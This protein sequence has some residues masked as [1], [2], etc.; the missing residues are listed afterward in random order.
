MTDIVKAT[1]ISEAISSAV[2]CAYSQVPQAGIL[3]LR[4]APFSGTDGRALP[5]RRHYAVLTKKSRSRLTET[6]SQNS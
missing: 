4:Y 1:L 5:R 6:I 2:L 3:S